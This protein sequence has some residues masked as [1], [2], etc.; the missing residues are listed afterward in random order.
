MSQKSLYIYV[1]SLIG[2]YRFYDRKFH[3]VVEGGRSL[4][5]HVVQSVEFSFLKSSYP[6][7]IRTRFIFRIVTLTIITRTRFIFRIVTLSMGNFS[8]DFQKNPHQRT[9]R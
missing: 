6:I 2:H 7:I 1:L 8:T 3:T 4:I 5:K 9:G